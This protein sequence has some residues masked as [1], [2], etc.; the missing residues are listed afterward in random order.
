MS[1]DIE[2]GLFKFDF[3]DHHAVLGLPFDADPGVIRKRYIKISRRLHPDACAS[4]SEAAKQQASQLFAKLVNPAY[5]QLSKDHSRAEHN[6]LLQRMGKQLLQERDKLEVTSETAKQLKRS[7]NWEHEYKTILQK[8]A[9]TQYESIDQVMEKI[10]EISELN[11]VY[12]MRKATGGGVVAPQPAVAVAAKAATP[13]PAPATSAPVS[14]RPPAPPKQQKAEPVSPTEPYCRRAEEYMAKNSFA[15]AILELKDALKLEPHSSRCHG[16]LAK[17]Y[18]RQ[19][20]ATMAKIHLQ[21]A[22]KL[23]PQDPTVVEAKKEFEQVAMRAVKGN[24]Q[25]TQKPQGKT[26]EKPQ[27]KTTQK[28]PDDNSKGGFFGLFGGKK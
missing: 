20:Q 5:E 17:A 25:P 22:L 23:N 24:P 19:N 15:K 16:L 1:F 7:N 8:L 27:G 21:Q 11:L 6:A 14:S 9:E 10:A 13:T 12:L 18:L 3:S 4:E 26:Q 2:R 28:K